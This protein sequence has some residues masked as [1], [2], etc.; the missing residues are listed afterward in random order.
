[1]TTA[2]EHMV[3]QLQQELLT[4]NAQAVARAQIA[5]ATQSKLWSTTQAHK[6][7]P[8]LNSRGRPK[9]FSGKEEAFQK[10]SREIKAFFAGLNK[11]SEMML[12]WS[13]VQTME[14]S[15]EFIDREFLPI[16]TNQERAIQNLEFVLQQVHTAR[17]LSRVKRRT[18]LLP[19]RGRTH[20]MHG[21]CCRNDVILPPEGGRET[22][23]VLSLLRNDA[24]F[25]NS[26]RELNAGSPRCRSTRRWERAR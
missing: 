10:W 16:M 24:L 4:L 14:I 1:M 15:T 11:E 20:W 3:I 25:S 7:A 12:E 6:D 18:T 21:G 22:F 2:M 23:F 9:E 5:A 8:I 13:S 19:T 26:K 17:V